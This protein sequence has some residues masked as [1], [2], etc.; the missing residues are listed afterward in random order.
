L[1]VQTG[2]MIYVTRL[3]HVSIVLNSHLIEHIEATPDTVISMTTG[4]KLRVLESAEEIIARVVEYERRVHGA[5]TG[6]RAGRF[7]PPE[8][9]AE[10]HGSH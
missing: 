6:H 3:N 8:G 5:E 7:T 1:R 2:F 4:E 10:T 9:T